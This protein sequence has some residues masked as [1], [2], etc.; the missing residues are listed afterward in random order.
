[1]STPDA[2]SHAVHTAN[3]R[4]SDVGM[5]L[6]AEDRDRAQRVSRAW[7]HVVR[8]GEPQPVRGSRA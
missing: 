8:D 1:M 4:L 7:L 6:D 3:I 2:F 5:A